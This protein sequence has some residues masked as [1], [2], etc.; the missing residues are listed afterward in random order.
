MSTRGSTWCYPPE[1]FQSITSREASGSHLQMPS[2]PLERCVPFCS[3]LT[4]GTTG[5]HARS[6]KCGEIP[7]TWLVHRRTR[8]AR[9]KG[10]LQP[11][12]PSWKTAWRNDICRDKQWTEVWAPPRTNSWWWVLKW[13]RFS[14]GCL[15]SSLS[16]QSQWECLKGW[17]KER[18]LRYNVQWQ[19]S[20]D[21]RGRS[22]HAMYTVRNAFVLHLRPLFVV[23][24]PFLRDMKVY[25]L[26]K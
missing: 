4:T 22:K 12:P 11:R 19:T 26:W 21:F 9:S 2:S 10:L 7:T 20:R 3:V 24:R 8:G 15:R 23:G 1:S 16:R 14:D 5:G 17:R 25:H 18:T 6:G 13:T